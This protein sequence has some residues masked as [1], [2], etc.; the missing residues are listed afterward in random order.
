MRKESRRK[1]IRKKDSRRKESRRKEL[2]RK[3]PSR[4][5][6]LSMDDRL[7]FWGVVLGGG[8]R[9][10]NDRSEAGE[11][12]IEYTEKTTGITDRGVC[13]TPA[14]KGQ[15]TCSGGIGFVGGFGT[16]SEASA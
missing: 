11:G 15:G 6:S 3:G 5:E 7:M 2:R 12:C 16:Q 14:R 10:Q 8:C 1:E 13:K 9:S 4:N